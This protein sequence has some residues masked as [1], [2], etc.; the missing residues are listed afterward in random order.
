[1]DN[2]IMQEKPILSVRNLQKKFGQNEV[3]KNISTD[4]YKGEKVVIVGASGSGKPGG[5]F[6][7]APLSGQPTGHL[8][9][10]TL[11]LCGIPA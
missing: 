10:R 6:L 1:M 11:C 7:P 2:V 8:H 5:G 9:G 3:L 4:I